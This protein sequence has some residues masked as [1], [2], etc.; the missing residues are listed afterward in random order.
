M[1]PARGTSQSA[2]ETIVVPSPV[3]IRFASVY[4]CVFQLDSA[5]LV[6]D[7]DVDL[8]TVVVF[9][10]PRGFAGP[11]YGFLRGTVVLDSSWGHLDLRTSGTTDCRPCDRVDGGRCRANSHSSNL[12]RPIRQPQLSLSPQL[13]PHSPLSSPSANS[14]RLLVKRLRSLVSPLV[15]VRCTGPTVVLGSAGFAATAPTCRMLYTTLSPYAVGTAVAAAAAADSVHGTPSDESADT[16]TSVPSGA[17]A[18]SSTGARDDV[19]VSTPTAALD[20][21]Q[22]TN[23]EAAMLD[24]VKAEEVADDVGELCEPMLERTR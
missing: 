2:V 21:N 16:A 13:P 10:P 24:T 12:R 8:R 6:V 9:Q 4:V 19:E 23:F 14:A 17:G 7:L 22:N 3:L 1:Y 18:G 5:P 11:A 20:G 15:L